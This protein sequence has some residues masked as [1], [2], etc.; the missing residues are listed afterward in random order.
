MGERNQA[1][2][3][4][5]IRKRLGCPPSRSDDD[6][7]S[8]VV[9]GYASWEIQHPR[10]RVWWVGLHVSDLRVSTSARFGR[11]VDG[12]AKPVTDHR[13]SVCGLGWRVGQVC[14]CAVASVAI[15]WGPHVGETQQAVRECRR[16]ARL[17]RPRRK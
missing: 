4:G 6:K 17:A 13:R 1:P 15:E 10:G 8:E 5:L 7:S 14:Q 11:Q 12:P 9:A 3:L 2:W 16:W